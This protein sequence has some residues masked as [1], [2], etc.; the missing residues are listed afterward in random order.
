M[1]AFLQNYCLSG[2]TKTLF[3]TIIKVA[4]FFPANFVSNDF[5]EDTIV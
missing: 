4:D 1:V 3:N 5:L 2:W